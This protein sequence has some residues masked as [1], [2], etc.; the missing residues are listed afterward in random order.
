MNQ[1]KRNHPKI[2][3]RATASKENDQ[4]Q[5]SISEQSISENDSLSGKLLKNDLCK[6]KKVEKINRKIEKL[7]NI[8]EIKNNTQYKDHQLSVISMLCDKIKTKCPHS[9]FLKNMNLKVSGTDGEIAIKKFD[10]FVNQV[11]SRDDNSKPGLQEKLRNLQEIFLYSDIQKIYKT[12]TSE[13]EID[14]VV[15]IKDH[16]HKQR[17]SFKFGEEILCFKPPCLIIIEVAIESDFDSI[18]KTMVRLLKNYFAAKNLVEFYLQVL[19]KHPFDPSEQKIYETEEI[20]R[21]LKEKESVDLMK[22]HPTFKMIH[23]TLKEQIYEKHQTMSNSEKNK[24]Y[25]WDSIFKDQKK[26]PIRVYLLCV[27]NQYK[28]E[29]KQNFEKAKK[30]LPILYKLKEFPELNL[31]KNEIEEIQYDS[32]N[33]KLKHLHIR[34]DEMNKFIA[35]NKHL[36]GDFYDFNSSNKKTDKNIEEIKTKVDKTETQM[37]NK[38]DKIE[39]QMEKMRTELIQAIKQFEDRILEALKEKGT[40]IHWNQLK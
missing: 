9:I 1:T 18:M 20:I 35:T 31:T 7:R 13:M 2:S 4:C 37:E 28:E 34:H 5:Q 21:A 39:I 14:G 15:F 36:K 25:Y 16:T 17:L 38:I 40:S 29:G 3:E 26:D 19:S 8:G 6:N 10:L 12:L 33:V 27:T 24:F 23:Q 32:G 30:L 22:N 11:M